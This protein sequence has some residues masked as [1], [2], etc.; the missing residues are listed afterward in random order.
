M[1]PS[2]IGTRRTAL[3]AVAIFVLA[4]S[5][6]G[7]AAP[8]ASSAGV[9]NTT[10]IVQLVGDPLSISPKTKPPQG[11]KIDFDSSATKSERS[12]QLARK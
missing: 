2:E 11:K 10:A 5:G 4:T 3:F 8:S 1:I 6:S 7:A 12:V 9:D